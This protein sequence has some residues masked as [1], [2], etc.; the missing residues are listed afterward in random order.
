MVFFFI[1]NFTNLLD[2]DI[3]NDYNYKHKLRLKGDKNMPE[4]TKKI[5]Q[6]GKGSAVLLDK[7][8]LYKTELNIGDVLNVVCTKDK[9]ILTKKK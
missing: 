8:I 2:N 7:E 5:I 4:K 3:Y 6:V 9:I 1:K